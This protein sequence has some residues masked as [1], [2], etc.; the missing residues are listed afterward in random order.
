MEFIKAEAIQQS[1]FSDE[2]DYEM[3]LEAI[4]TCLGKSIIFARVHDDALKA[5]VVLDVAKVV[6]I[7]ALVIKEEPLLSVVIHLVKQKYKN[8]D[9]VCEIEGFDLQAFGF[10]EGAYV[11]SEHLEDSFLDESGLVE[12][13]PIKLSEKQIVLNYLAQFFEAGRFYSEREVNEVLK[14]HISFQDYVTLRRDLFDFNYLTRSLDEGT[15]E[16]IM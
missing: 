3:I 9:L 11:R 4:S 1:W 12:R 5:I 2:K 8:K 6:V 10:V 14:A 13:Y 7:K 15:Y 16:N